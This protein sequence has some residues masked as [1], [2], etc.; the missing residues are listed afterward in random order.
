VA[1]L[2]RRGRQHGAIVEGGRLGMG[3][4]GHAR[5]SGGR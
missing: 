2:E 1:C 4:H 3:G 5:A